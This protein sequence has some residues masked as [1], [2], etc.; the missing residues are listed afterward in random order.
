MA[1]RSTHHTRPQ[2]AAP[3]IARARLAVAL[4]VLAL[5]ACGHVGEF[6]WVDDYRQPQS[7]TRLAYVIAP[8]DTLY[9]RVWNQEGLSSKVRVRTDGMISLPFLNDVLVA[10]HDPVAASQMLQTKLK[11]FIVNPVVTVSV[12]EQASFELSV[13]GEVAKPGVYRIDQSANLLKL[14]AIA[15]GLTQIAG[16]DRIFVL[17]YGDDGMAA[18]PIR[19]RFRYGALTRAE[20]NA[21]TF[22]LKAGDV[23]VVE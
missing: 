8:G 21:A 18:T 12:E 22:R 1:S 20:G 7:P 19:I 17:R 3:R 23:V 15:G 13:L 16:R 2:A 11:S 14:L 9:V 4:G 5:V 10:G 6:V